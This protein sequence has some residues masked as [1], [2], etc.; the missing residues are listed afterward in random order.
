MAT[1]TRGGAAFEVAPPHWD[2]KN[3]RPAGDRTQDT[4]IKSQPRACPP[5]SIYIVFAHQ[6]AIRNSTAFTGVRQFPPAWLQFGY[7]AP[8]ALASAPNPRPSSRERIT[9]PSSAACEYGMSQG[10]RRGRAVLV[11]I[12]DSIASALK[13]I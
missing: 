8:A 4:L 9:P 1:V 5:V 12:S 13:P 3:G 6:D 11:P 10:K 2:A 7:S